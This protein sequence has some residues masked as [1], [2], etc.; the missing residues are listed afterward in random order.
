MPLRRVVLTVLI[1]SG[2]T[3]RVCMA[4]PV[5]PIN[6][7]APSSPVV[8]EPVSF[9]SL[10]FP[11]GS[12]P[13]VDLSRFDRS[14]YVAP[15][16]YY[17]DIFLNKAWRTRA[18]IV[19]ANVPGTDDSEPCY[20]TVALASYGIDLAKVASDQAYPARKSIPKG[21]FC[22]DIG[23]Y[24]PGASAS[25]DGS[26]QALSLSVPQ[27]YI[28]RTARG[29]VEPSQWEAG[30]DAGVLNYTANLYSSAQQRHTSTSGYLGINASMNLGSW[31]AYHIGSLNWSRAMATR[32][33]S[34]ATYLQHDIPAWRTQL[35]VGDTFTSGDFFDSVRLRGVR[36]YTDDRMLPQSLRG[37]APVVRG[38]AET[39]AHVVIRQ[40]GYIIYD[41]T[42]A[43]GPF[44]IDD[45]Y[46]T[47]Y[48]GDL[49]IEITEADG[50]VRR[51]SQPFSA[52]PQLLRPGVDRLSLAAGKV[53]QQN[54]IDAP[55]ILQG[56]YQRGLSNLLTGYTGAI[57]GSGYFSTLIG[58]AFNTRIG[59]FST[60]LTYAST[61]FTGQSTLDGGSLRVGYDK[62][63]A[64][65]GTNLSVAAY[66][67]STSG[68]VG[69]NDAVTL[70]DAYA[71][72]YG[73]AVGRQRSRMDITLNQSLGDGNRYG[74]LYLNGSMADYWN[75]H[76][77]QVNLTAGY[78]NNW[79]RLSYNVSVQRTR[80]SASQFLPSPVIQYGLPDYFNASTPLAVR[81][82][83][84]F[85]NATLPMGRTDKSP[86]LS[87][88]ISHAK[89]TGSS[90]QASLTGRAGSN[91]RVSYGATVG[92]SGDSSTAGLN[93]QYN[94]N[95]ANVSGSYSY[96]SGYQQ[97]SIGA[98][99]T[100]VAHRGGMTFSPPAGDT[101]G[102]I[103]A[104][105]AAGA[106]VGNTQGAVVDTHGYA[107]VPYLMPYQVNAVALDPKGAS[108]NV[109]LKNS[110][111]NV[112]PRAGSVVR[113]DY[114]V[115]NS[116]LLLI[117]TQLPDGR[118][119]PFGADVLNE[120]G[121]TIGVVGQASRLIVRGV[122]DNATLTVRWGSGSDESCRV[123]VHLPQ[124]GD[125]LDDVQTLQAPCTSSTIDESTT[126]T[127][128]MQPSIPSQAAVDEPQG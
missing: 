46:P 47:G 40:N 51:F 114:Q 81:D 57:I 1:L 24:I 101:I 23:D 69:L 42:V 52:V 18:D 59:A 116:S 72:G 96:G 62:N 86:T 2:M 123:H 34:S 97:A 113:L 124:A 28:S 17:G 4:G 9:N 58:T 94:G 79:K 22:G 48:G 7:A 63:L 41:T 68:F 8:A 32:Y 111:Q 108:A 92:R 121:D 27:I 84:V 115:D 83:L 127:P 16:T 109:E 70:R 12:A 126:Q 44:V 25:F 74:Q 112:A 21:R 106:Q 38:V 33:Q 91:N 15:G 43:P 31:H 105:G 50:R 29:Y 64:G 100:I 128:A 49:D 13:Q 11:G 66:R 3:S 54:L 65:S 61:S 75:Q 5:T 89:S 88:M 82:T 87:T 53:S 102:L 26:E 125:K 120:K 10:F 71:R 110:V 85:F 14:G 55:I 76:G 30:V 78:S 99:G 45:L 36:L 60:D 39:N 37:Y 73:N 119:V 122:D 20:D 35:V 104:P 19:F 90:E 93:G 67:Y 77:R 98:T 80:D 103:Y 117:D 118:P 56:T 95:R 107:I 6:P